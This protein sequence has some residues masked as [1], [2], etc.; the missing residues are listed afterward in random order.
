MEIAI[1]L[2]QRMGA[3]VRR[4]FGA[5]VGN[6]VRAVVEVVNEAVE[7]ARDAVANLVD[8]V[9]L[10][11][12]VFGRVIP[13][14]LRRPGTAQADSAPARDTSPRRSVLKKVVDAG[15][16]IGSGWD[17]RLTDVGE[18]L[19]EEIPRRRGFWR[20]VALARAGI[21][22]FRAGGI[23]LAASLAYFTILSLLPM[24]ALS[25]MVASLFG[26]TE[27]ISE[28]L[29]EMLVYYFPASASLIESAVDN[30]LAG[31]L[32]VGLVAVVGLL[33]GANGLF[34]AANRSVQRIFDL[35]P[36]N[37]LRLTLTQVTITTSVVSLFLLSLGLTALF[38]IALT[39]G[40]G[41]AEATGGFSTL[42]AVLLG[43]VSTALPPTLTVILFTIVYVRLPNAEVRWKDA[44]FGALISVVLFEIAKHL[45][46]WFTGLTSQRNAVYGPIASM[47]IMMMWG[48][49]AGLI[50]MYGA[51]ITRAAGELRPSFIR[52]TKQP[53]D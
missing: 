42:L 30:L 50:F 10:T 14:A 33:M 49:V 4:V 3:G 46:F 19:V 22:V 32:V 18:R 2:L 34:M 37:P 15:V 52:K 53:R 1:S 48:Y 5:A 41:I 17:R 23:D 27:T 39:F 16:A 25:L 21:V 31:S 38:Q 28:N 6:T 12:F 11:R 43:V 44:A 20:V 29:T 9:R 51:A 45:F 24:V 47:V 13:N 26:D 40:D 8:A 35:G 7:L 36:R